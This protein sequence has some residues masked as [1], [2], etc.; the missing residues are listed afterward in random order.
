MWVAH[1]IIMFVILCLGM[2]MISYPPPSER[3]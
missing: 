3:R 2:S 1:A